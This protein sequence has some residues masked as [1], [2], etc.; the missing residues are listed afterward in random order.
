MTPCHRRRADSY[1]FLLRRLDADFAAQPRRRVDEVEVRQLAV[2]ALD[3]DIEPA[4]LL[5]TQFEVQGRLDGA[6][7]A[8]QLVG[9]NVCADVRLLSTITIESTRHA[10]PPPSI[11]C[12]L[13][14][15]VGAVSH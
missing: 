7:A 12:L 2:Q 3:L 8:A 14:S 15:L 5:V 10:L 4:Q 6:A 9:Q 13:S 1:P 11:F